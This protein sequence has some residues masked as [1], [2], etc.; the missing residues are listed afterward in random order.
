[1]GIFWYMIS[2]SLHKFSNFPPDEKPTTVASVFFTFFKISNV[3]AVLPETLVAITNVFES[4]VFG[5]RYPFERLTCIFF[6]DR[7]ASIV[8]PMDPEP[9]I[10]ANTT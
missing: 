8:S 5:K 10:P 3:S 6:L 1:M 4:T 2:F 9:P 7:I